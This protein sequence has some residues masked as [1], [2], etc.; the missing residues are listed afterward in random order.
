IRHVIEVAE[1]ILF[2]IAKPITIK[3]HEISITASIG[4]SL[5]P[6]HGDDLYTLIK[7]ADEAL[8]EVK[9]TG[10]NNFLLFHKSM[11]TS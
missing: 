1:K 11:G 3:N 8:Y 6:Q 2:S 9:S 10:K 5:Y 7:L 4:I